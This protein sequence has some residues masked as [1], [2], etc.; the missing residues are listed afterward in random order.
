MV[1]NTNSDTNPSGRWRD[2]TSFE[3]LVKRSDFDW[4]SVLHYAGATAYLSGR[5]GPCPF[6]GGKDRF[7]FNLKRGTW[8][9]NHCSPRATSPQDFLFK[10]QGYTQFRELADYIRGYFGLNGT[11]APA[12]IRPALPPTPRERSISPEQALARMSRIWNATREVQDGDPVDLYLRRRLPGLR[13]IPE[14]IRIHPALDY[15]ERGDNPAE[16]PLKVGTFPAMIVRGFDADGQFVQLH[17]TYLTRDGNK[18]PVSCPKKTEIGIGSNSYALRL[19][20]PVGSDLGVAEGI[21]TALAASILDGRTVWPCHSAQIMQNFVL[22]NHLVGRVTRLVIYADSD[23]LKG[24][25][26]AGSAAA[27][28]LAQR[29]KEQRLKTLIVR[30]AKECTDMADLVAC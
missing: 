9:C 1:T 20:E 11:R 29:C 14:E 21:E 28:A 3:N 30:P 15:W 8:W 13:S 23:A 4:L 6:C 22:P 16:G 25:K 19:G 2:E 10:W 18:A 5:H 27:A 12:A 17:K 26:R 7:R 24:G